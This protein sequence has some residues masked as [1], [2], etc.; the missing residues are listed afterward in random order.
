MPRAR[1]LVILVALA[2]ALVVGCGD[3][4][5]AGTPAAAGAQEAQ[6]ETTP[7]ELEA[8]LKDTST[9]PVI[10]KPTGAAPRKLVKE[11]IVK[12]KGKAAGRGD[13]VKVQYVGVAFST[14]EQ[15]DA[16]WDR[17]QPY[18]FRLGT[19]DV[20]PGWD[21]GIV[22]MREGGR[23]ELII[24]PELAYGAQGSPP[25]IGPNETLVFVVDLVSVD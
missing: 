24:P 20:I 14:G 16:T 6:T 12:G 9:K 2:V 18:R 10:E 5:T 25:D 17:G 11:D 3:D 22:G 4:D 13:V 19:G 7:A 15:F 8:R 23:R 21:R 1:R